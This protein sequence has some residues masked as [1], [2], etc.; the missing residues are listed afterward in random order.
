MCAEI[1]YVGG[2][3]YLLTTSLVVLSTIQSCHSEDCNCSNTSR[4]GPKHCSGDEIYFA[5]VPIVLNEVGYCMKGFSASGVSKLTFS[6]A[7][8]RLAKSAIALIGNDFSAIIFSILNYWRL[9]QEK[10]SGHSFF[11]I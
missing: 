4:L 5:K 11:R 2:A 6:A 10:E 1:Y 7:Y 8:D 3:F 9:L